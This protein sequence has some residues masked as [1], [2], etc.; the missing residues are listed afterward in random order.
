MLLKKETDKKIQPIPQEFSVGVGASKPFYKTL[1]REYA[2]GMYF[3]LG[4]LG[5]ER[6]YIVESPAIQTEALR[7]EF[8]S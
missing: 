2:E 4:M 3:I 6:A 5:Y 8:S 7:R 1:Y